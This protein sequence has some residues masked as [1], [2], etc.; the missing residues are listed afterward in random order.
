[1]S[2]IWT[3]LTPVMSFQLLSNPIIRQIRGRHFH[4][5]YISADKP[6]KFLY[7]LKAMHP[8][9]KINCRIA[10]PQSLAFPRLQFHN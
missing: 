7:Y 1:M 5:S 6:Q 9:Y 8:Q 3:K 4:L 2:N 10:E